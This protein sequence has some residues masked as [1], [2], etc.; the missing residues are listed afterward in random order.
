VAT[1][2]GDDG[3]V[4]VDAFRAGDEAAL[5]EVYERWSSLV[6]SLALRSLGDIGAAEDVTRRVF[7]QVWLSRETYEP[8][9]HRFSTWLVDLCR[10]IIAEARTGRGPAARTGASAPEEEDSGAVESKRGGLAE[11]LLLADELAHLDASEREVLRLALDEDLSHTEIAGRTGRGVDEVKGLI[12]S[13]LVELRRRLEVGA[14]A[15]GS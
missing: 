5:A 11:R 14:D 13:G 9:R 1:R 8:A 15:H 3:P 6:Y 10:G 4:S 12:A 7:T 2:R